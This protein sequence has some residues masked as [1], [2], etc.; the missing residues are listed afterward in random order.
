MQRFVTV[1]HSCQSFFWSSSWKSCCRTEPYPVVKGL[2]WQRADSFIPS[3]PKLPS[4]RQCFRSELHCEGVYSLLQSLDYSIYEFVVLWLQITNPEMLIGLA[5][6]QT[7]VPQNCKTEQWYLCFHFCSPVFSWGSVW[8][9]GL[10]L[11]VA[12]FSPVC[13]PMS[14][15]A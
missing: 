5:A 8:I 7:Y 2:Q 10:F 13:F 3:N 14:C 11:P 15:G 4:F 9:S 6:M 1:L 12:F